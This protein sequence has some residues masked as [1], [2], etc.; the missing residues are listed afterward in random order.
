VLAKGMDF[1]EN[2]NYAQAL[3]EFNH[4]NSSYADDIAIYKA[5]S[6]METGKTKQ[7]IQLLSEVIERN[8]ESWEYYQDAQWYLALAYIKAKQTKEAKEI[9]KQIVDDGRVYA[10]KAVGMLKNL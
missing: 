1:Y 6:L 8:G 7:A 3:D 2:K 5:V 4:I 10:N 9:L